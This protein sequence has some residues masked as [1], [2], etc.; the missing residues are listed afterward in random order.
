MGSMD[1]QEGVDDWFVR[2]VLPLEPMVMRF[3][4]RN[5]RDGNEIDDLRQEA[6]VRIYDAAGHT[7]PDSAKSFLFQILRNLLID[8]RQKNKVIPIGSLTDLDELAFASDEASPE[9]S[10]AARQEVVRLQEALD[11]L[12]DRCRAVVVLRKVHCMS[13]REVARHMGICENTVEQHL[14][15][16]MRILAQC[17]DDRRGKLVSQARRYLKRKSAQSPGS[18]VQ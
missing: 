1:K 17:V 16:G 2:E 8:R 10:V 9:R 18:A 11:E 15:K 13:Q 3:L 7:R 12:S 5:W 14:A 6:Y 4:R